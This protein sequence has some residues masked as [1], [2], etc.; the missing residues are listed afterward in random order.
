MKLVKKVLTLIIFFTSISPIAADNDNQ[1]SLIDLLV[2]VSQSSSSDTIRY[3]DRDIVVDETFLEENTDGALTLFIKD[4]L[5]E[6]LGDT[7][8]TCQLKIS[9]PLV[10]EHCTFNL[11][12][13]T[14]VFDKFS[15][16]GGLF[17]KNCRYVSRISGTEESGSL[18]FSRCRFSKIVIEEFDAAHGVLSFY[19]SHFN[20]SFL[21]YDVKVET[22]YMSDNVFNKNV[23]LYAIDAKQ[24][25]FLE[26]IFKS[27][28]YGCEFQ[29]DSLNFGQP[30]SANNQLFVSSESD[31]TV[32]LLYKNEFYDQYKSNIVIEGTYEGLDISSNYIEPD[33][34]IQTGAE[35]EF[36]MVDNQIKGDVGFYTLKLA[37][38]INEVFW[39][40]FENSEIFLAV[41]ELDWWD[42]E[43]YG[44]DSHY[45][46]ECELV[47]GT[48]YSK[49][50]G[51]TPTELIDDQSFRTLMRNY[52]K[53]YIL[54]KDNG[55]IYSANQS[56]VRMRDIESRYLSAQYEMD[57]S[58]STYIRWRLN[59]IMKFYTN[60]G[61][62]P[63]RAISVSIWVILGFA[64]VYV[65][66]PSTWDRQ[67]RH[68]F[69]SEM[70]SF[71]YEGIFSVFKIVFRLMK[72]LFLISINATTLSLNA[73]VTLGFGR[74]PTT[75][76]AR[77]LCVIQGF[78]GWFLLSLFTVALINQV[79]F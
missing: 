17:L 66:F 61:T 38:F 15:F 56:Y 13:Q 44:Y 79:L 74:I 19:E 71:K 58:M 53:L 24:V 68:K 28:I 10:F 63:A 11:H 31:Q 25:G 43:T 36:V 77:Y 39:N 32:L 16:E 52:Y 30:L 23:N 49:Y 20:S 22:L 59:Q 35:K 9:Q 46:E 42:A 21:A 51:R 14:W 60:H 1:L 7:C 6:I 37:E 45:V 26:S 70:I 4:K 40:Q 72:M 69:K 64:F 33:L 48:V 29:H 78:M 34:I 62:D 5:N 47:G 50:Y 57:N 2:N 27:T 8:D 67:E 3:Q 75:G 12:A 54:F 18:Q 65:F 41:L 55:D 73:F 76:M